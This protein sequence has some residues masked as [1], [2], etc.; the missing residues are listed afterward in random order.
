[1]RTPLAVLVVLPFVLVACGGSNEAP[2]TKTVP[3]PT[4]TVTNTVEKEVEKTPDV[5]LEA[6]D[7]ADKGFG[8]ATEALNIASEAFTSVSTLDFDALDAQTEGMERVNGQITDL[9]PKYNAAKTACRG[10]S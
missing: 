8:Y 5:C 6:L 1:M 3:G 10:K 2:E 7:L 9:A 4:K